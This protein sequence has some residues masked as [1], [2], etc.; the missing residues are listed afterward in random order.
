MKKYVSSI[1]HITNSKYCKAGCISSG[2]TSTLTAFRNSLVGTVMSLA[3]LASIL[4]AVFQLDT[5]LDWSSVP[6][7][8]S[9]II[10]SV[11]GV[12][13]SL[14]TTILNIKHEYSTDAHKRRT[15]VCSAVIGHMISAALCILFLF[16]ITL[17]LPHITEYF[18]SQAVPSET[19]EVILYIAAVLGGLISYA[20]NTKHESTT[21]SHKHLPSIRNQ[22]QNHI[23]GGIIGL[24]YLCMT[25]LPLLFIA[26]L[27][28]TTLSSDTVSTL[29]VIAGGFAALTV[30]V[31]N[32]KQMHYSDPHQQAVNKRRQYISYCT[33]I[34][35]GVAVLHAGLFSIPYM[36]DATA[37]PHITSHA[38]AGLIVVVTFTVNLTA[39]ALNAIQKKYARTPFKSR[40]L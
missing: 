15:Y 18:G 32:A 20:S 25:L 12:P 5:S 26:K 9:Y 17:Y 34:L 4:Y 27:I 3:V 13:Y 24:L 16:S 29:V 10:Y 21:D 19:E 35:V 2:Q 39:A 7:V 1:R 6:Q 36:V 22:V 31:L 40:H 37:E 8:I 38:V 33:G 28:G 23:K 11:I 14:T 30:S